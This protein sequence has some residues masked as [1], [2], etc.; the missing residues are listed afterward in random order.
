[1]RV[2]SRSRVGWLA[3]TLAFVAL[4]IGRSLAPA[5]D[6]G[7]VQDDAR[8]HVFWMQRLIDPSLFQDD[9]FADYFE[10][11]SPPGYVLLYRVLLLFAD[12]LTASKLLPPMLG[13][14]AALFTFLLVERL[15]PSRAAAFLAAV[16]GGWYVWQ[17][18]DLSS[19]SPRALLLPLTAVLLYGLV[20]AW[21]W[22]L[23]GG[24]VAIEALIYPSAAALGVVLVGARLVELD[25]WPPR[26][27]TDWK[28]WRAPIVCAVL[29][30]VILA[31]TVFGGSPFGPAVDRATAR[32][33]PEFG[34]GGRNAFFLP[35]PYDYWVVS[36]RSGFDLRV[37]D[38][39]LPS[40]PIFYQLLALAG[41][42]PLATIVRRWRP[43][44]PPLTP[45]VVLIVQVVAGSLLLFLLAH[46]LLFRLYLPARFV[47][48]TVP[49]MLA[50]AAG[51]GAVA[52]LD[53]LTGRL[54]AKRLG[55]VTGVVAVLL[56]IGLALYPARFDGNFVR[57][58]TPAITAY[59]RALPVDTLVV[60][61]PTETDSVP[62]FARRPV[63]VNREYALAYH[64]GF[65]EQVER[66]ANDLVEAYYAESPRQINELSARY[67]VG[68]FLV[69]HAAFDP[70]TAADA[71]SGSFEPYTSLV[72]EK[73]ERGGR[74]ALEEAARRCGALSEGQVTVVPAG[75]LATMR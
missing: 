17:Y 71:W 15:Y 31:P 40:L 24:L 57:D 30:T 48:W 63:L 34:P 20:A 68:V 45:T 42:L 7:V 49:L 2:T 66:R 27:S 21:R 38:A 9:L 69:N 1:V 73:T 61:V 59:L 72:L 75:C 60:G 23:I 29:S 52:L 67:G 36:Y 35:D 8:Q 55:L 4:W 6:Q 25:R 11:Q 53:G 39:L 56:A 50:I 64:L 41:L 28:A 26:L 62:A 16:L 51:V 54:R 5:L 58:P 74:F 13:L 18:D 33:M 22:W 43:G 32:E 70:A 37:T 3:A 44:D 47:A 65:Y 19:G 12:P 46:A 10:S 14:V